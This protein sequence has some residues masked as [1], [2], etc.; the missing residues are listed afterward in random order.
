MSEKHLVS[1]NLAL[2]GCRYVI[3]SF[4]YLFSAT[5]LNFIHSSH[6]HTQTDLR[7]PSY[8]LTEAAQHMWQSCPCLAPLSSPSRSHRAVTLVSSSYALLESQHL[9]GDGLTLLSDTVQVCTPLSLSLSC[10][11]SYSLSHTSVS[12]A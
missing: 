4:I 6:A 10:L 3:C 12:T 9:S 2:S 1:G 8:S 5:D 11:F 7:N